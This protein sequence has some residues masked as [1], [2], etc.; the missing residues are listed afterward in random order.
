MNVPSNLGTGLLRVKN[1]KSR[2]ALFRP[3]LVASVKVDSDSERFDETCKERKTIEI[4]RLCSNSLTIV[5]AVATGLGKLV[6]PRPQ[7][8]SP[9][10]VA[11]AVAL[12][13]VVGEARMP[14]TVMKSS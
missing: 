13:K 11:Y 1:G 12:E 14:G 10:I 6:H 9:T 3:E 8:R 4:H 7:I 5:A 2:R